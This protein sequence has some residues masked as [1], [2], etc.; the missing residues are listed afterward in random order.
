MEQKRNI[1]KTKNEK[2]A[3]NTKDGMKSRNYK[4]DHQKWKWNKD[5]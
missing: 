4:E 5:D 2:G 3:L 1:Y